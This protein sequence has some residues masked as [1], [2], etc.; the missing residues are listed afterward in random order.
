MITGVAGSAI[1]ADEVDLW[2]LLGVGNSRSFDCLIKLRLGSSEAGIIQVGHLQATPVPDMDCSS[3]ENISALAKQAWEHA[4]HGFIGKEETR[5]FINPN[6]S[7]I[8]SADNS[9]LRDILE[10]ID[11]AVARAYGVNKEDF[12]E[13]KGIDVEQR[14][15][16]E[17]D[18]DFW[19]ISYAIGTAFG[20]W[21]IRY[22]T[23][24][25]QPPELPDPFA[26]LPVCPPG[27]LQN[28]EGLPAEA[29]DVPADYP[30]RISCSGILVDDVNHP[31]DIVARVRE[32]IELIWKDRA[33]VIEQEACEILGV[34]S[35]RDYFRRPN[36]FFADHLKRYSKSRRQAPIY[37]PLSTKSGSYT[38]WLYYH[39]L[40]DQTLHTCLADFLDPKIRKVQA[41]LDALTNS[42]GSGTRA[43]EMRE[44]LDELQDLRDEIERVIKLPWKPNLND[45]V[46]ITA[47][48]LH[49]LF[50]LPKWQKDLKACWDKLARG[51]FDWAHLAYT[52]WPQRV[53]K[54]CEKDLS[55]AIAH[56]R[57]DLCKVEIPKPKK[58]RG[59]KKADEEEES[60]ED[61]PE[62]I[63]ED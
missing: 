52:I 43:R 44:F 28:A 27:M 61:E 54:A 4:M 47:S 24:E 58:V 7:N 51:E 45:G 59:K 2:W 6:A 14:D 17:E 15:E 32:A 36:A 16:G 18:S 9:F 31:E 1:Y 49:K 5:Y 35:L 42:G 20:R 53:E 21:D 62:L 60:E 3:R 57:E 19:L 50:R 33:E 39:R 63:E 40:T 8:T 13:V 26:P 48:P 34:K 41:E 25:R 22:A 10:K 38:L 23:G 29:K 30:L 56:G 12:F 37:W 55:I 11:F 46:L